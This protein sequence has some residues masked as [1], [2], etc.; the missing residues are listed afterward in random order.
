MKKAVI[1]DLDGTLADTLSSIT[2]F[3]NRTTAAYGLSSLSNERVKGFVG[4]GARNLLQ[5]SF[6]HLG[7][8]ELAEAAFPYYN[9]LYNANP[10]HE[11]QAYKGIREM[12]AA[13]REQ[14][15]RTAVF[16]NKPHEATAPI[17][18]HLFGDKIEYALGEREGTPRK[19]DI[20]GLLHVCEKLGVDPKEC[21]Y[22]GDSGSDM[23]TGK[24]A[25][26][27]TVGVNWGF[28]EEQELWDNGADHVIS[29]PEELLCLLK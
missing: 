26:M 8:P 21:A 4:K 24:S 19:P 5:Q 3:V 16:S 23:I 2:H 20:T 12:L 28:R 18:A 22:V 10:H 25:G 9:E 15:I 17:C 11:L 13:L 29:K 7:A 27:L 14:N 6:A 1:F